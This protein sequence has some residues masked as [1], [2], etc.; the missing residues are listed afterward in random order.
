MRVEHKRNIKKI[1]KLENFPI[2]G[3]F[4]IHIDEDQVASKVQIY[5]ISKTVNLDGS[6][7]IH[8]R[9][10]GHLWHMSTSKGVKAFFNM[11]PVVKGNF[12]A[13]GRKGGPIKLMYRRL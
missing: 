3:K 1:V 5:V 11:F 10:V 6:T 2:T 4:I 12:P 7:T 13:D 8:Q 9:N